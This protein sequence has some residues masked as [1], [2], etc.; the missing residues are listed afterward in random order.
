MEKEIKNVKD[1]LAKHYAGRLA[2]RK[3]H[4]VITLRGEKPA[5]VSTRDRYDAGSG[6]IGDWIVARRCKWTLLWE[7]VDWTIEIRPARGI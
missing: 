7:S 1:I 5:G 4:D 6:P 2:Y 3:A